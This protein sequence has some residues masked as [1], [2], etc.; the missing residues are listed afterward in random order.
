MRN[1]K[2]VIEYDGTNYH[3]WQIQPGLPTIQGAIEDAI[4]RITQYKSRLIGSGRTD[5]GVHALNQV[6]NFLTP[7]PLATEVLERALNALLPE[8]IVV[9]EVEGV[10]LDFHARYNA[11]GKRY[12]YKLLRTKTGSP[13]HHRYSWIWPYDLTV[14]AMKEACQYL[15]GCHDFS[16]FQSTGSDSRNPVRELYLLDI[17]EKEGGFV[18]FVAEANG[19]LRGMVRNIVGTLVEIGMGKRSPGDMAAILEGRDRKQAGIKAPAHGL[20]LERVYYEKI[21][22]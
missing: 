5:V 22:P 10:P 20:F 17:Q 15:L 3:G 19:F 16:S 12:R 21:S 7:S 8:D 4:S 2:L 9:K 6:A 18:E 11:T 14:E 13:F 1:I